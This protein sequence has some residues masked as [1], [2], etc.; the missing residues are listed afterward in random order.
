M[1]KLVLNESESKELLENGSI[2]IERNGF[3][4][5]VEL[6]ESSAIL[7]HYKITVINPFERIVIK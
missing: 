1:K 2:E 7:S 4:I 6:E 3:P 5:I